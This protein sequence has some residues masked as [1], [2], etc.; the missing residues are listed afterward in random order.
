MS[1]ASLLWAARPPHPW[2]VSGSPPPASRRHFLP[3][4]PT[5]LRSNFSTFPR[6]GSFSSPPLPSPPAGRAPTTRMQTVAV[7]FIFSICTVSSYSPESE[8]AAWRTK[9]TVSKSLVRTCTC[10]VSMGAPP[11]VHTTCGRGFPC[12]GRGGVGRVGQPGSDPQELTPPHPCAPLRAPPPHHPPAARRT[13]KGMTRLR[14]SP[15]L[16]T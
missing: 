16:R 9:N 4:C 10:E 15:T 3:F 7:S 5:L 6:P 2:R 12:P 8:R 13:W 1:G 14:C 11:L